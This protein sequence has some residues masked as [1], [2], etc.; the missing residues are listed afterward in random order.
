M[1]LGRHIWSSAECHDAECRNAA[2]K[3]M[4]GQGPCLRS[5][6][7]KLLFR[8]KTKYKNSCCIAVNLIAR[9]SNYNIRQEQYI[10]K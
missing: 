3:G 2:W 10:S 7:F 6:L 9:L 4:Y 5:K 8:R 1:V